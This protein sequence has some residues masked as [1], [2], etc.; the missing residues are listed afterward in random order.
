[1]VISDYI[2]IE[3]NK[4]IHVQFIFKY[5]CSV[6]SALSEQVT[7]NK[8]LINANIHLFFTSSWFWNDWT[9]TCTLFIDTIMVGLGSYPLTKCYMVKMISCLCWNIPY[10]W[11]D[12][13]ITCTLFIDTI[14]VGRG[15]YP[16]TS[17]PT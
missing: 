3:A 17:P 10:L 14:M 15:S 6:C 7:K 4:Y 5:Y 11:N 2:F 1:M 16:L 9:V 8:I 12:W 13:T